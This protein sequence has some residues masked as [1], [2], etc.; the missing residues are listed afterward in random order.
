MPLGMQFVQTIPEIRRSCHS[1][2]LKE[3]KVA[4]NVTRHKFPGN[5]S[6]SKSEIHTLLHTAIRRYIPEDRSLLMTDGKL[7]MTYKKEN[8]PTLVIDTLFCKVHIVA[9]GT[10]VGA[11]HFHN[12]IY[13]RHSWRF[14]CHYVLFFL[15]EN[16]QIGLQLAM[17]IL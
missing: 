11:S 17:T 16:I 14:R 1:W 9:C 10:K 12:S 6:K 8:L 3:M 7:G 2:L 4:W 15:P 5:L 13:D